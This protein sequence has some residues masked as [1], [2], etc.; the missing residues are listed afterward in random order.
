MGGRDL[1]CTSLGV[2]L[3]NFWLAEGVGDILAGFYLQIADV[4]LQGFLVGELK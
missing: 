3:M 2:S 4:F 1:H